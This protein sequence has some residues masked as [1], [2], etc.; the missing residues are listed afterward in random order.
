VYV[1]GHAVAVVHLR[2]ATP[3]QRRVVFTRTW[4]TGGTHTI[5][6]VALGTPSHPVVSVDAFLVIR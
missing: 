4:A 2:A 5:R 3:I 1:D 6:V